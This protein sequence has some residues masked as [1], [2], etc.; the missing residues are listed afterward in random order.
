MDGKETGVVD[1]AVEHVK[2]SI[3]AVTSY[4]LV[5][6]HFRV[7]D[8]CRP[9]RD[10]R[11]WTDAC[12]PIPG[13]LAHLAAARWINAT[14]D[15]RPRPSHAHI[16]LGG[17]GWTGRHRWQFPDTAIEANSIEAVKLVLHMATDT[18]AAVAVVRRALCTGSIVKR[19]RRRRIR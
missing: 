1:F 19:R 18:I 13:T 12:I 7:L 16:G 2:V 15:G 10:I 8:A 9:P 14:A 17:P 11:A 4:H 6:H 3:L 5:A